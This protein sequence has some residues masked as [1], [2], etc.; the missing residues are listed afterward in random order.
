MKCAE[1]CAGAAALKAPGVEAICQPY[2]R[3]RIAAKYHQPN[4]IGEMAA[5]NDGA[6]GIKE[7]ADSIKEAAQHRKVVVYV[8]GNSAAAAS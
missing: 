2:E 4:G 8:A 5:R 6:L 7:M 3:E 1:M